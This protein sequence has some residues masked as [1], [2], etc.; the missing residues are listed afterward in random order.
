[1]L[2]PYTLK[3]KC[4]YSEKRLRSLLIKAFTREMNISHS[5]SVCFDVNNTIIR[6]M[7]ELSSDPGVLAATVVAKRADDVMLDYVKEAMLS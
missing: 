7:R 3:I 5:I 6:N 4:S 1:M 2:P